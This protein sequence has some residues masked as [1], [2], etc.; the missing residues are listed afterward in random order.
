MNM[1]TISYLK[2]N[3]SNLPL[4]EPLI[5]T[6]NGKPVYVIESYEA[7]EEQ[8]SQIKRLT[9]TLTRMEETRKIEEERYILITNILNEA[10]KR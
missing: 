9:D 3:A 4:E 1:Q 2:K 5:I 10:N 6:Q 8:N 7:R